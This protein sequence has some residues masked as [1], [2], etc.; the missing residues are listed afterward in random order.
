MADLTETVYEH[1]SG[2]KTFTITCAE[3]WSIAMINRLALSHPEDVDI[4]CINP[5]GSV[6]ARLPFAWMKIKPTKRMNLTD[7][8][9][10]AIG[11]RLR[12][13]SN[14]GS[15]QH[16]EINAPES[17]LALLGMYEY[18]QD[19]NDEFDVESDSE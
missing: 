19:S 12:S 11:D 6:V 16:C 8:Q 10:K 15:L 3:R 17:T 1:V 14:G 7:E 5:D 13:Y 9:K 2:R 4:R 18:T